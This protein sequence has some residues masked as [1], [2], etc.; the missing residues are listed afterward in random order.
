MKIFSCDFVEFEK[1]PETYNL[2]LS[3]VFI[4]SVKSVTIEPSSFRRVAN[5]TIKDVVVFNFPIDRSFDN[6]E[7]DSITFRNV[8]HFGSDSTGHYPI[9]LRPVK[10]NSK[11]E[12]ISSTL[13]NAL[14]IELMQDNVTGLTISFRNCTIHE[15]PFSV[16]RGDHIEFLSNSFLKEKCISSPAR[17]CENPNVDGKPT[18]SLQFIQSLRMMGNT[19]NNQRMPDVQLRQLET[20]EITVVY[21][22]QKIA[23]S[24]NGLEDFE[25]KGI[26]IDKSRRN[27]ENC[28]EKPVWD[29]KPP[30]IK[31]ICPNQQALMDYIRMKKLKTVYDRHPNPFKSSSSLLSLSLMCISLTS[32]T[33]LSFR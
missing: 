22:D 13:S 20:N 1:R 7:A 18:V 17:N 15:I 27:K 31:V 28:T 29:S 10:I 12:F 5:L 16:I 24:E 11:L 14:E 19:L 9:H 26:V 23:V 21:P 3:D 8:T 6:L 32:F 4:H 33:F 30:E 25:F 2:N